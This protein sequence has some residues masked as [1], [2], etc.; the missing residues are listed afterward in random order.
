MAYY[1]D[2]SFDEFLINQKLVDGKAHLCLRLGF[3]HFI[4]FVAIKYRRPSYVLDFV[5][6]VLGSLADSV[7]VLLGGIPARP[8]SKFSC[9]RY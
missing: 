3:Q 7:R 6:K 2:I 4:Q 1:L 5:P 8:F 9:S